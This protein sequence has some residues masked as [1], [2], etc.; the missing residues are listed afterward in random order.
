MV[1]PRDT[2]QAASRPTR[3]GVYFSPVTWPR[4]SVKV[5]FSLVRLTTCIQSGAAA[6]KTTALKLLAS[7]SR[8]LIQLTRAVQS[9]LV[10]PATVIQPVFSWA[11]TRARA[12]ARVPSLPTLATPQRR[13]PK[14]MQSV[15]YCLLASV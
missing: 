2:L 1:A 6:L 9:A 10:P 3:E 5:T 13:G 15:M 12:S 14:V 7:F 11:V 8:A 4:L